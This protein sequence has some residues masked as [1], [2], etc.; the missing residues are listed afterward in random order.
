MSSFKIFNGL[1][2]KE[3]SRIFDVG[4]IQQV[5]EGKI[6]F[7]KG[8]SGSDMY[9]VLTG[10]IGIVTESGGKKE[11]IAELGP[12]ELFGEVAMFGEA[13]Q[14]SAGAVAREFSQ[15]LTL[16]E[17]TFKKMV[18]SKVP[19]RFLI[20]LVRMLSE[21]LL[22]MHARYSRAVSGEKHEMGK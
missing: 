2:K 19:K 15:V 21:R 8:D 5:E 18:E 9:A 17:E 22:D 4:V 13:H 12:G 6:L 20:N 7:H 1:T 11:V 10:K 3:L 16:S 14:R